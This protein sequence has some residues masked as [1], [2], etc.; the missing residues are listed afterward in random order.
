MTIQVTKKDNRNYYIASA[1]CGHVGNNRCVVIEFPTRAHSS[2]EATEKVR[3]FGRVK[4][5]RKD[6]ILSV[7]KVG[8]REFYAAVKVNSTDEYLKGDSEC[9]AESYKR[10]KDDNR[11]VVLSNYREKRDGRGKKVRRIHNYNKME[12]R[13]Y[14]RNGDVYQQKFDLND[15]A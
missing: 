2:E 11:I 7:R 14:K 12:R 8:K 4:K 10:L 13:N 5:H 3:N 15:I 1:M 6:C 9:G